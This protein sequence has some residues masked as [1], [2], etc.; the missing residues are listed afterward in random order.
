MFG[1]D[2][3]GLEEVTTGL[4]KVS[5]DPERDAVYVLNVAVGLKVAVG[6]MKLDVEQEKFWESRRC[7]GKATFRYILE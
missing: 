3:G 4:K 1:K 6:L 2:V 5:I 7:F